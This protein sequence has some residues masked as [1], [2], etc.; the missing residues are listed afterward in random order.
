MTIYLNQLLRLILDLHQ[1]AGRQ[2]LL[3][4]EHDAFIGFDPNS[5]RPEL[6]N[7]IIETKIPTLMALIAY[8][9]W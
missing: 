5:S 6:V 3:Y 7:Q 9:I 1:L 8:S 2:L 4:A